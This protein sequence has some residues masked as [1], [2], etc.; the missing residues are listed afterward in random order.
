MNPRPMTPVKASNQGPI[1]AARLPLL[2]DPAGLQADLATLGGG[3][4]SAHFNT[5]FFD[6]DWSGVALRAAEGAA[7]P[8]YADTTHHDFANTGLLRQ[9]RHLRA[10]VESFQCPL[11][12][13]R[14]L[15]LAAGSNIRE[16]R[17]YD[18]GYDA[19]EVRIHVPVVTNP[20]VEFFLDGRRI[21]MNEGECWYLDLSLP[22]R[23][24][25]RSAADRVHLVIDCQLNDWLRGL[26]AQGIPEAGEESGFEPFRRR[27]L[28]ESALQQ[29]LIGI[30]GREAFI[31]RTVQ[32]GEERGFRFLA[33]D[34]EAAILAARRSW[35]ER[36][37]A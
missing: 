21:V 16:H 5:Q 4:W 12:S 23:V 8:M 37:I 27:V 19:G 31:R 29:Q 36:W 17:D 1:K 11:R 15:K 22:H 9:C 33:G 18:L 10:A 2:F 24:Q 7:S 26:I 30:T 28:Q 3:E 32:L 25:N 13:V 6:G 34:V 20:G 35:M 14:L